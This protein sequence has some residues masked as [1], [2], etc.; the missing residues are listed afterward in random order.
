MAVRIR[1]KRLGAKKRPSYRFVAADSRM[2]RDGRFI[3]TL[4]F[5]NPIQKPATIT[6]FEERMTY[7]FDQ[8]AIPSD[9]VAG[10]LRQVGFMKKYDMLKKGED[11]SGVALA[12]TITEHSKKRKSKK[13]TKSE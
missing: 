12:A 8:G 6:V 10:L 4:G 7:W 9:T 13:A 5:Y 3:E 1:L 2:P 11:V